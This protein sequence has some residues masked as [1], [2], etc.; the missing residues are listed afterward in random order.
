MSKR[1]L[2]GRDGKRKAQLDQ[3]AMERVSKLLHRLMSDAV[4]RRDQKTQEMILEM[5]DDVKLVSE[6]A[7][8]I[9][10]DHEDEAVELVY[11]MLNPP[12]LKTGN[13]NGGR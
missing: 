2:S 3:A 6:I 10:T 5:Q 8:L 13:G 11:E 9:L 7:R 4:R 1:L 12:Q